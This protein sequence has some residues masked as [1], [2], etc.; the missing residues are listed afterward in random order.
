[1]NGRS[2]GRSVSGGSHNPS[3]LSR[4]DAGQ[5]SV[6]T[7]RVEDARASNVPRDRQERRVDNPLPVD[8]ALL[9]VTLD[10]PT[11]HVVPALPHRRIGDAAR[12]T[13]AARPPL[14]DLGGAAHPAPSSEVPR[15]KLPRM[16]ALVFESVQPRVKAG[17]PRTSQGEVV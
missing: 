7:A 13:D 5:V 9:G 15:V 4:E 1:M 2:S 11:G 17:V 16:P 8:V 3:S 12:R 10:P 6:S 14:P